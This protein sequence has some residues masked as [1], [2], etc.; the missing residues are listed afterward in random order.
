V[1]DVTQANALIEGL[2]TKAVIGDKGYDADALMVRIHAMGAQVVI[3]PRRN[4][5]E[6]RAY[7]PLLLAIPSN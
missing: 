1:A 7:L 6:Q 4:R 2:S 5:T 3:P